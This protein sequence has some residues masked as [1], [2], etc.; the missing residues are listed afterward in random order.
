[1]KQSKFN[2]LCEGKFIK[3]ISIIREPKKVQIDDTTKKA[4]QKEWLKN[5]EAG[6]SKKQFLDSLV[7]HCKI[8]LNNL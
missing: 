6:A 3:T 5:K 2:S 7:K 8:L 1:M 4:I